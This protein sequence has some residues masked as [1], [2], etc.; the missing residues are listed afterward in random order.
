MAVGEAFRFVYS[1]HSVRMYTKEIGE[2]LFLID[3]KTGVF[4]NL[5]FKF[6]FKTVLYLA[7]PFLC[8]GE[9]NGR[10]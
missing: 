5:N 1:Y 7:S 10:R 4:K 2:N 6:V 8:E 3:L 9:M